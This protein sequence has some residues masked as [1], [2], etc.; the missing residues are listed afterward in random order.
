MARC[1]RD[2]DLRSDRQPEFT[3]LD[4]ETSFMDQEAIIGL[5]EGLMA[6]VFATVLGVEVAAP[7]P[8]LSYSQAM[9]R[10]GCDKPDLRFGLEMTYVTEAV[11][12]SDFRW[13][14]PCWGEG[15]ALGRWAAAPPPA[16]GETVVTPSTCR[17]FAD[18]VAQGGIV[19]GLRVPHGSA[20]SNSRLKGKGDIAGRCC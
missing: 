20:I 12:G 8:R 16:A 11:R 4:L 14:P 15:G 6:R 3:Q 9:E 5:A 17:L 10:Y 2:E 19:Q 7:F 13:V 1:F 18:A